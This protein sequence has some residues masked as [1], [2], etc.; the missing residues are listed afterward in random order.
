MILESDS[1]NSQRLDFENLTDLTVRADLL[2]NR[3]TTIFVGGRML[4]LVEPSS[5][6]EVV[7]TIAAFRTLG[8]SY[9]VLGFGSNLLI[10]DGGVDEWVL[11]LGKGLR[12]VKALGEA[13][14]AVGG[15]MSLMSLCRELSEAGFAGIEFAGGIPAS[16]GGAVKMNAGAHGGEM[17]D[18]IEEVCFVDSD[19]EL[20]TYHAEHLDFSYRHSNISEGAVVVSAVLRLHEG[21]KSGVAALRRKYLEERKKRQPLTLPSVGSVFKNPSPERTAGWYIE[22]AG[23]KGE[24]L[25]GAEISSLHANWIVNPNRAASSADVCQLIRLCQQKVEETYAVRLEPELVRW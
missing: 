22:Q 8:I 17:S 3:F 12:S 14:F 20:L 24:I 2:G 10:P 23:L 15:A 11:K 7:A 6:S 13:R 4:Y 9:R 1:I 21:D 18:L 5:V 25:G 16:I 19:G